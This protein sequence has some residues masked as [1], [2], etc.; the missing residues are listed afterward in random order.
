MYSVAHFTKNGRATLYFHRNLFFS[1]L[2]LC[3]GL[4]IIGLLLLGCGPT[5]EPIFEHLK[6]TVDNELIFQY[7]PQLNLDSNGGDKDDGSDLIAA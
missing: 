7:V 6:H 4:T 2:H 3:A 1:E 5:F